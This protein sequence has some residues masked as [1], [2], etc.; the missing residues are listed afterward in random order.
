[1][2]SPLAALIGS[3]RRVCMP[4]LN[5]MKVS[6]MLRAPN[7]WAITEAKARSLRNTDKALVTP[8]HGPR[9]TRTHK[10]ITRVIG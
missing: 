2:S 7:L 9:E 3:A 8:A 10:M 4:G 6:V 5:S 1:L